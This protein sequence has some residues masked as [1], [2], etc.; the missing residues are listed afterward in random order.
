MSG[1][2]I[3]NLRGV[4][5]H[6][7]REDIDTVEQNSTKY[8]VNNPLGAVHNLHKH[9][10]ITTQYLHSTLIIV[11]NLNSDKTKQHES[12]TPTHKGFGQ[13]VKRK[14]LISIAHG[15]ASQL[16]LSALELGNRCQTVV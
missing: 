6:P 11:K 13:L 4:R 15:K 9:H 8:R 2:T 10:G 12:S 16:V 7:P 14:D 5:R 1:I 3:N